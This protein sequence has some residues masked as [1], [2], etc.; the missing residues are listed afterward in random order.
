[1]THPTSMTGKTALVL[2][3]GGARAAYQV[4]VLQALVMLRRQYLGEG[5][6]NPFGILCGTSAGAINA[7]A[8]ACR[9]DDF[10]AGVEATAAVWRNFHAD[11]V[12]RTDAFGIARS[13]ARWLSAISIGW[14]LARYG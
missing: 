6:P 2:S 5:A 1:M 13:G 3:G 9:V 11:Q 8:L 12:Y 4:G 10:D 14:I 7:A